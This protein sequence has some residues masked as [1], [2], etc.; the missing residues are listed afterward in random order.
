M[1]QSGAGEMDESVKRIDG[2]LALLRRCGVAER[3]ESLVTDRMEAVDP[4]HALPATQHI[5]GSLHGESRLA[6][7][8]RSPDL[9]DLTLREASLFDL[10]TGR[11]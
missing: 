3:G 7:P 8:W 6:D 1:S 11:A 9:S 4:D 2:V 10:L 5:D